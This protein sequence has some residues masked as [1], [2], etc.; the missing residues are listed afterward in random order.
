MKMQINNIFL[1]KEHKTEMKLKKVK[2]KKRISEK[3]K[4]SRPLSG[5]IA[6][7]FL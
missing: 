2:M 7:P 1:T 6:P 5:S 3:R 4:L